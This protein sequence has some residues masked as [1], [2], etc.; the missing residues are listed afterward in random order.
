[1]RKILRKQYD[2]IFV[3]NLYGSIESG[4]PIRLLDEGI[5]KDEN[6]FGNRCGREISIT[7]MV[8]FPNELHNDSICNI[9]YTEMAGRTNE[10]LK[11]LLDNNLESIKWV[12][13]GDRFDHEFTPVFIDTKDYNLYYNWLY[14]PSLFKL[15][16]IGVQSGHD[17]E[18][19]DFT[20]NDLNTKL[21]YLFKNKKRK[22]EPK[23]LWSSHNLNDTSAK[24][25]KTKIQRFSWRNFDSRYATFDEKLIAR[26]RAPLMDSLSPE[27]ENMT[28]IVD[29]GYSNIGK[30]FIAFI[31]MNKVQHKCVGYSTGKGSY[32]FP[33]LNQENK[34]NI[35]RKL[36]S[37]LPY[38]S[39]SIADIFY[40]IYTILFSE[41]YLIQYETLI[42]NDFPN[43]PFPNEED[44]FLKGSDIGRSLAKAHLL[45]SKDDL[46]VFSK[47]R[48]IY[49][50]II[51]TEDILRCA[52]SSL[53]YSENTKIENIKF[54][55]EDLPTYN[56]QGELIEYQVLL[57]DSFFLGKI[58]RPIWDFKIGGRKQLY[59][60]L[61]SRE[62][63]KKR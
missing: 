26:T 31:S 24:T 20:I 7:F 58:T 16:V 60:W 17:H 21:D 5:Q 54:E 50:L 36:I 57:N 25:A 38:S 41:L 43:I 33:L 1:M 47:G 18:V 4:I 2:E 22:K 44:L 10:K 53:I 62:Y 8:R 42:K 45:L 51:S 48:P 55:G 3:V 61:K 63:R 11:W 40:Y 19:M 13:V 52:D 34:N 59:E 49:D 37:Y 56:D 28:I 32:I 15:N 9:Y 46:S 23:N 12:N 14:L 35:E 6:V 29:R 30:S 27:F 39:K